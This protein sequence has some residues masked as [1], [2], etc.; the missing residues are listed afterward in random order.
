MTFGQRVARRLAAIRSALAAAYYRRRHR[1][2]LRPGD[3]RVL[4]PFTRGQLDPTVLA[5]AVRIARIEEAT[6]VPAYL[7]LV[8]L[9]FP[10]DAPMHREVAVAIPLLEAIEHT[11]LRAGVP[12]DARMESGRTPIHAIERLWNVEDFDRVVVPAP[13]EWTHGFRPEELLWMLTHAP[14]ETV[15]LRPDPRLGGTERTPVRRVAA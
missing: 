4:I 12:V 7:I 13:T 15:I 8:P 11:A 9:E 14:S 1:R 2:T 6:L 10:L 3:R 5:A